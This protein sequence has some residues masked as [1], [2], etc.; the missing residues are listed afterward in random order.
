METN[1]LITVV[2]PV[3][4]RADIVLRTLDSIYNQTYRPIDLIIVDNASTDSTLEKITEWSKSRQKG[5]FNVEILQ[6]EEAGAACARNFGLEHVRTP[7]VMFFDSDDEMRPEHIAKVTREINEHPDC[8]LI[9]FDATVMDTDGWSHAMSI[10][11]TNMMRAHLFHCI[12]STQRMAIRTELAK[13]VGGW[14]KACAIW[15]DMELGV[16]LLL[17]TDKVRK[18]HGDPM[19]VIHPSGD[20]SLTGDSYQTRAGKFEKT[21]DIIDEHF[22]QPQFHL[23]QMWV[24]SRRMILAAMYAREGKKTLATALRKQILDRHAW[25]DAMK[26]RAVYTTQRLLGHGGSA[27]AE[28]FFKEPKAKAK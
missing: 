27:T 28:Y 5:D 10:N 1:N 15:D 26:L 18:L 9:Y 23:E 24:E 25:S 22:T 20:E 17:S 19:V 7:W 6:C 11:D 16:R 4:N 2:V 14:N 12:L 8:Q 3:H 21:L 13:S